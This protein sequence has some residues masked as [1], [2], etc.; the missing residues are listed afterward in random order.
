[1]AARRRLDRRRDDLCAA[2]RDKC[3]QGSSMTWFNRVGARTR[4][5]F[6]REK[7][8]GLGG[9]SLGSAEW[10]L[11]VTGL[12]LGVAGKGLRV[13]GS[14]LRVAGTSLGVTESMLGT[15]RRSLG[16]ARSGLGS[17]G[18]QVRAAGRVRGAPKNWAYQAE[19][20]TRILASARPHRLEGQSYSSPPVAPDGRG[21]AKKRSTSSL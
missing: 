16:V 18:L 1:M 9:L 19:S 14:S 6:P 10:C 13:A 3:V 11:G 5:H 20:R 2:S 21:L 7:P 4:E 15:A 8:L 17:S 12:P